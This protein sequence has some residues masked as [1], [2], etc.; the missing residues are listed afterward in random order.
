M[1]KDKATKTT[2]IAEDGDYSVVIKT[3]PHTE[4][5]LHFLDVMGDS[6]FFVPATSRCFN[7]LSKGDRIGVLEL[8]AVIEQMKSDEWEEGWDNGY[9]EGEQNIIDFAHKLLGIDQITRAIIR[10]AGHE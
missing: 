4:P 10:G 7:L 5:E 3:S 6:F 9:G 1:G 8:A 2:I